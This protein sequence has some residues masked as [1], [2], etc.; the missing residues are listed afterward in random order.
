[1]LLV[2]WN[3]KLQGICLREQGFTNPIAQERR[4]EGSTP[5]QSD[6]ELP[7]GRAVALLG[8]LYFDCFLLAITAKL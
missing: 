7:H 1:M 4:K 5:A 6:Q 3:E 8:E 2:P